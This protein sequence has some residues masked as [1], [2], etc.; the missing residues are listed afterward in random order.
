LLPVFA[1]F[2]VTNCVVDW[3]NRSM[4]EESASKIDY[5][6][7]KQFIPR[8]PD[9]SNK[10]SFGKVL[11]IAGSTRYI[12]AASLAIRAS[13]R[14]GAGLVYAAIPEP[15]QIA[16]AS[17]IAEAIW[18][19]LPAEKGRFSPE[20]ARLLPALLEDKNAVLIGPGLGQST[21]TKSLL[22]ALLSRL[23]NSQANIPLLL[24]AD[25]LNLLS[26]EPD[27]P[28][29]LPPNC[30]LTPHPGEFSRLT[31]LTIEKI[32]ADRL[33]V[34]K[35]YAVNWQQTLILKG[36]NTVIA[37][38]QGNCRI[39]SFANSVLAHG[40]T[41]DVLSGILVSLLAQGLTPFDAA[42]LAVWLHA[43]AAEDALEAVGHPAATLPSDIIQHL[44]KAL[45]NFK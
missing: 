30:L 42:S 43:W 7:V 13:L 5:Y 2:P 28:A 37:D 23:G 33:T 39:L 27:W 1:F 44:G 45:A 6:L 19:P 25:A 32:Q 12:G 20:A 18:Y 16:L 34:A 15:I 35:E 14:S 24:D 26:Q 9:D 3:Y 41:G 8:R 29:L 36:A 22:L 40:G 11:I 38:P 31:G 10:G 21:G 17:G 4:N